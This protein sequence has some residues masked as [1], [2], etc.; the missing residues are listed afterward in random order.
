MSTLVKTNNLQN[1]IGYLFIGIWLCALIGFHKTYTIFFPSFKGFHWQHHF[2]GIMLMS[3]FAMLIVQPFLIK[4]GKNDLH[5]SLGKLGYIL[6]PLVC[7][8]IFLV[9][10]IF[11]HNE[12]AATNEN[13]ALAQLALMVP[14]IF[15][16]GLFF[17]LAML[18]RH[19]PEAHMRYMVGTSLLMLGPGLG[20]ALMIYGNVSPSLTVTIVEGLA[21]AIAA[22]LLLNDIIKKVN[23]K[24]A[25]TIFIFLLLFHAA[26]V[27]RE[28]EVWL[29]IAKWFVTIAF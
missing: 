5:R 28:S 27:F 9:T 4:Y 24:P 11:Y 15:V 12:L 13:A 21:E 20:R 19:N 1:N 3:W 23:I 17:L 8:S 6:A 10:K 25:L 29:K 7:Y 2:H 14:P 18:N 16:F 26:W 22:I